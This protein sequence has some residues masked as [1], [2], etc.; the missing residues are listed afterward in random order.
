MNLAFLA[1]RMHNPAL[2]TF[3]S[4]SGWRFLS[5]VQRERT[6]RVAHLFRRQKS[7]LLVAMHEKSRESPAFGF[8]RI[9]RKSAVISTAW[10][11]NVI[12]ASSH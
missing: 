12:S 11:C 8:I 3:M 7:T 9:N 1:G 2:L 5:Q 4:L 6:I 10:M